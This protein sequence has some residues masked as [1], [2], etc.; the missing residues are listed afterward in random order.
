[1]RERDSRR[2]I[3]LVVNYHRRRPTPAGDL[4]FPGDVFRAVPGDGKLAVLVMPLPGGATEF[5]PAARLKTRNRQEEKGK[6]DKASTSH[7]VFSWK[8][9]QGRFPVRHASRS[10]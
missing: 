3:D 6:D 7:G 10:F 5:R 2:Q 1:M 4:T 9:G 8:Q